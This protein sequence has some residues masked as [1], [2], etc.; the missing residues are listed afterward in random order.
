MKVQRLPRHFFHEVD[1]LHRHPRIPEK[2]DV[3]AG[4]EDVVRVMAFEHRILIGPTQ[5]AKRPKRRRKPCIENVRI[6]GQC[7]ARARE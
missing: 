3:K 2:Q 1:T 7:D 5:G 6:T 4:N